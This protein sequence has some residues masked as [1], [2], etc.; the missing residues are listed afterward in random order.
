MDVFVAVLILVSVALL[1]T[2]SRTYRMRRSRP[3]AALASGGWFAIALGVSLGPM[4]LGLVTPDDLFLTTPLVMLGLGWIGF[5][6][7][8]QMRR[9]VVAALPN[10]VYRITLVDA[11]ISPLLF[12]S[13]MWVCL[14]VWVGANEPAWVDA[15]I[16]MA[17][18]SVGWKM[19]T[20]SLGALD[21]APSQRLA[22]LL[23]TSGALAGVAAV[24]VLAIG[25]LA[26]SLI[27]AGE[28]P[29][30][31]RP[32][33]LASS[34]LALA[35]VMALLGRFGLRL[36]G[37]SRADQLAVFLGLVVFVAGVATQLAAGAI[38]AAML[39]GLF[40]ANVRGLDLSRFERFI[41]EAEHVLASIFALLAGV[42]LD[43]RI[44]AWGIAAVVGVA[45]I[46][47]WVKPTILRS[48]IREEIGGTLPRSSPLY[49]GTVRQGPLAIALAV[50]LVV[51][52]P[53]EFHRRMLAVVVLVGLLSELLPMVLSA[54]HRRETDA[55]P[56][57]VGG[58]G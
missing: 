34:V 48:A 32:A 29:S 54:A 14:R 23:R 24:L 58:A 15:I 45:L 25:R 31:I 11:L 39:T 16:L 35:V 5:M 6:I 1:S 47:L 40:L 33:F 37:S 19:E 20:R 46:R 12:G 17:A 21:T 38:V 9:E 8:L 13:W 22:L 56:A 49:S 55:P 52:D 44:G 50:G 42:L 41:I 10:V 4:V 27:G 2:S 7:G 57:L 43:L 36:A 30:F 53:T 18:C 3:V 28:A 26:K 51:L